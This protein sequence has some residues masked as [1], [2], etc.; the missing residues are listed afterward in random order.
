M[1]CNLR[2]T[3]VGCLQEVNDEKMK[4]VCQKV[5]FY[6]MVIFLVTCISV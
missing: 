2:H 6:E 4:W 3:A 5:N 1:L